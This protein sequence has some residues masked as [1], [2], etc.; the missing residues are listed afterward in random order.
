MEK[1]IREILKE[2][3]NYYLKNSPLSQKEI[4]DQLGISKGSI[5][6]WLAGSNSPSIETLAKLCQ[7]LGV[8][9]SEMLSEK[10]EITQHEKTLLNKYRS[11]DTHG[12]KIIDI[13]LNVE[14]ERCQEQEIVKVYRA[15]QSDNDHPAE[16]DN[17][18]RSELNQ[19]HSL[20]MTD[21]DL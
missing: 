9:M 21:E 16:I 2:N 11:L 12:K 5:T 10:L 14:H 13:I 18:K 19:L 7:I 4:A 3:L 17:M 6:N 15:A 20:P 8:K 1:N